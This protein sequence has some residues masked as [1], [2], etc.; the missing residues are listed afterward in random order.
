M[1]VTCLICQ[2]KSLH[3]QFAVDH[4]MISY[5]YISQ[6]L[7][8]STGEFGI[9]YRALLTPELDSNTVQAVAVKTLKGMS[10]LTFS[11]IIYTKCII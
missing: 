6:F 1:H 9:V 3:L 2:E 7:M 8:Y 10:P 11:R 5:S 4:H